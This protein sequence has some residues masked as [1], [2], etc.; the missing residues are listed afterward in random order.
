M[1]ICPYKGQR[2]SVDAALRA[3]AFD[4]DC[5]V[6]TVDAVQGGE[7][8]IVFLL[9]TR[10]GGRV[11]FLLDRNRIN[12]ALS[13]ARDAV[14]ILGHRGALSPGGMGP[15]VEMIEHG[16]AQQVLRVVSVREGMPLTE[17][18][19]TVFIGEALQKAVS[20]PSSVQAKRT[21]GSEPKAIKPVKGRKSTQGK[22]QLQ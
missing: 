15:I 9:M 14:Y 21:V 2:E 6:T 1:I 18:A 5:T 22:S 3:R 10:H 4:F 19:R 17:L 7:A 11:H 20:M 13:R 12:V 8:D 16:L